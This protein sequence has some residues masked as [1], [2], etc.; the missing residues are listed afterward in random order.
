MEEM[1]GNQWP[2]LGWG[3][4][5]SPGHTALLAHSGGQCNALLGMCNS[6]HCTSYIILETSA[7]WGH[8]TMFTALLATTGDTFT[9][10]CWGTALLA[11]TLKFK[12]RLQNLV[13]LELVP[14]AQPAN[15]LDYFSPIYRMQAEA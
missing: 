15:L 9:G 14:T 6:L 13:Q 3:L 10:K 5:P 8:E 2:P 4:H 7:S 11:T 12:Y 1:R